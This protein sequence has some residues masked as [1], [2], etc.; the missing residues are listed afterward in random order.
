[1]YVYAY[2]CMCVRVCMYICKY[3][4]MYVRMYVCISA[5]SRA[6]AHTHTHRSSPLHFRRALSGRKTARS[7]ILTRHTFP[8]V[9]NLV[10]LS[11]TH[12][13]TLAFQNLASSRESWW[14]KL[15]HQI[16]KIIPKLKPKTPRPHPGSHM[17]VPP[18][19]SRLYAGVWLPL[20]R[21][22]REFPICTPICA[23]IGFRA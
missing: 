3:I 22:Y 15:T 14:S 13:R 7:A 8:N 23:P 19:V 4:Y 17:H 10:T 5:H 12:A 11:S 6:R 18:E 16:K 21:H 20:I 9:S 2:I 1:M